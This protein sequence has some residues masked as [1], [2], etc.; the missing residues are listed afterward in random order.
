MNTIKF[1]INR[2]RLWTLTREE[3]ARQTTKHEMK[4]NRVRQG[5]QKGADG[6][7]SQV[8]RRAEEHKERER[9]TSKKTNAKG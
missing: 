5:S 3:R 7:A 8:S 6:Q 4:R 9:Q 1:Q 2:V